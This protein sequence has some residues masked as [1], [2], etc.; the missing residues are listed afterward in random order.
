LLFDSCAVEEHV[1]ATVTDVQGE[2]AC[3]PRNG[4][5]PVVIVDELPATAE[6]ADGGVTGQVAE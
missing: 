2:V 3:V 4:L 6:V 5:P 1:D